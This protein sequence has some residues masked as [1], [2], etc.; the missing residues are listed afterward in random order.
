MRPRFLGPTNAVLTG[1]VST[2]ITAR[3]GTTLGSGVVTLCKTDPD[4]GTEA[5]TGDTITVYNSFGYAFAANASKRCKIHW[6]GVWKILN[7][8]C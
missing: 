7:R 8:E 3:S 2:T 1:V 4:A 6:E 5:T